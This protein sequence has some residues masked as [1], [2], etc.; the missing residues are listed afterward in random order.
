MSD[1]GTAGAYFCLSIFLVLII[2]GVIRNIK[3]QRETEEKIRLE[4]ESRFRRKNQEESDFRTAKQTYTQKITTLSIPSEH[5]YGE[6]KATS[7]KACRLPT[8][9]VFIWKQDDNI[10]FFPDAP[11]KQNS[12]EF[13]VINALTIFSIP[14]MDVEHFSVEGEKTIENKISG[15]GGGGVDLGGAILG[16]VIAG[17]PG[18]IIGGREKVKDVTSSLVTH[19]NRETILKYFVDGARQSMRFSLGTYQVLDDLIPE[20]EINV[21]RAIKFEQIKQT[22]KDIDDNQKVT[23][24]LRELKMLK[25][26]GILTEQEFADKKQVLLNKIV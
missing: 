1:D 5:K 17:G 22:Q 26:E 9:S 18:A 20:K 11:S 19:D 25:D 10:C 21:V 4:R 8:G 15:G 13:L 24:Q 14:I 16:G 7:N 2:I 3:K 6:Y 23:D 12:R